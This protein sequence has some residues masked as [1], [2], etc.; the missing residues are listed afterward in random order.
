MIPRTRFAIAV[1]SCVL[2]AGCG[3]ITDNLVQSISV[4]PGTPVLTAGQT[5]NLSA[6]LV[7]GGTPSDYTW[8]VRE[9]D[10]GG[11][12]NVQLDGVTGLHSRAIY[13]APGTPGVYHV[14]VTSTV[15]SVPL[16]GTATIT[17]E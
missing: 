1:L 4:E 14:D 2:L 7:E 5:Q 16:K 12:L 13:T 3:G 17:V 9:G 15:D 11:T 6:T 10:A 8:T